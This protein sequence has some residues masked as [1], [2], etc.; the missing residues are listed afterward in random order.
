MSDK[1]VWK[2]ITSMNGIGIFG[3]SVYNKSFLILNHIL[4]QILDGSDT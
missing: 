4:K 3:V 1:L 2:G